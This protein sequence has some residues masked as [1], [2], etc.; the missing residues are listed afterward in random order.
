MY[1]RTTYPKKVSYRTSAVH[2]ICPPRFLRF[3]N[4]P[5]WILVIISSLEYQ[6]DLILHIMIVLVLTLSFHTHTHT[7][8]HTHVHHT[9]RRPHTHPHTHTHTHTHTHSHTQPRLHTRCL[10]KLKIQVPVT[11]K[12]CRKK[13]QYSLIFQL[14]LFEI[15]FLA[16]E[17][18]NE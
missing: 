8:T 11:I 16:F 5:K 14:W 2:E 1:L 3:L 4:D 6:I 18:T 15:T 9:H 13:V 10:L 12:T 17:P 7:H